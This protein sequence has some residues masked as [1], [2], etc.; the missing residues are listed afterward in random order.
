M[1]LVGELNETRWRGVRPTDPEE[2]FTRYEPPE[3]CTYVEDYATKAGGTEIVYTVPD[4]TILYLTSVEFSADCAASA[5]VCVGV[6]NVG[7]VI[8]SYLYHTHPAIGQT[9]AVFSG[10]PI[11]R[12]IPEKYDIFIYSGTASLVVYASI[13][14]YTRSTL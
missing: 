12:Q 6:R 5:W 13:V 1:K 4:D 7:D 10:Y 2:V 3:G 11:A 9:V 8:T 14:G